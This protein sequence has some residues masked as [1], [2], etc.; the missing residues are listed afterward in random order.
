M[1]I[2]DGKKIE[3]LREEKGLS[4]QDLGKKIGGVAI[5]SISSYERGIKIPSATIL[6]AIAL[7]LG[8]DQSEL[9]YEVD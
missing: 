3:R 5:N 9:C 4:Q 7:E 6:A 1:I 2:V 8:V